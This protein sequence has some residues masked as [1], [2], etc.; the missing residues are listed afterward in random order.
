MPERRRRRRRRPRKQHVESYS[1][2]NG[3]EGSGGRRKLKPSSGSREQQKQN[4]KGVSNTA[5][6]LV[7]IHEAQ[8]PAQKNRY[9]TK[10]GFKNT[11][12]FA[13]PKSGARTLIGKRR[14]RGDG[15]QD[16]G[17][18]AG[19][20]QK[21]F[22]QRGERGGESM[23]PGEDTRHKK[24]RK[25]KKKKVTA[26]KVMSKLPTLSTQTL[27]KASLKQ[28]GF[29]LSAESCK[30]IIELDVSGLDVTAVDNLE[31]FR[32]L[33]KLNI[34]SNGNFGSEG[35]SLCHLRSH[36][37]LL[38][39]LNMAQCGVKKRR[40]LGGIRDLSKLRVLNLSKNLLSKSPSP[41]LL[42]TLPDLCAMI[43]ND[44]KIS[45]FDRPLARMLSL[46]T[47]VLSHNKLERI[48]PGVLAQMPQLVK[49]SCSYNNL[50][51]IPDCS[52]L[53]R[54]AE[55]RLN[56]NA[57]V[58][59]R[60]GVFDNNESLRLLALQNNNI[61]N[62]RSWK[63]LSSS[64][65]NRVKVIEIA[66]NPASISDVAHLRDLFPQAVTIDQTKFTEREKRKNKH[67]VDDLLADSD[68]TLKCFRCG[69][70]GHR[71]RS[72]PQRA[73]HTDG[74]K[75]GHEEI[76]TEVPAESLPNWPIDKE[77]QEA[78]SSTNFSTPRESGDK[79]GLRAANSGPSKIS[80]KERFKKSD[81]AV[82]PQNGGLRDSN[83]V[84]IQ[85]GGE[86]ARRNDTA[87]GIENEDELD[88][89]KSKSGFD[90]SKLE[91]T[92]GGFGDSGIGLGGASVW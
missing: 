46:N 20:R 35:S 15:R 72:C 66:G 54:L 40:F 26:V 89:V 31:G 49:L 53:P 14:D 30:E 10:S 82:E 23:T 18:D 45:R 83:D 58:D 28:R 34:S 21:R 33:R 60:E 56:H 78:S 63:F 43:L 51:E 25:R 1:E 62:V 5:K 68:K 91:R 55:L 85:M 59:V 7:T 80:S 3:N 64:C 48:D 52:C 4:Y 2:K 73:A 6:Q 75:P 76:R 41:D 57:I 84:I 16:R 12:R 32:A 88:S 44:N 36:C 69:Q 29:A 27:F 81:K 47:L 11:R 74:E 92:G 39:W 19:F 87:H 61:S 24:R 77:D 70:V 17:V 37:P 13:G 9:A 65:G 42:S 71:V 8:R 50:T 90:W 22:L 79:E 38:T 67:I 86:D